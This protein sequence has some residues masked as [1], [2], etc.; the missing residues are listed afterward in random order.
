MG[1][2][3]YVELYVLPEQAEK[4]R[5]ICEDSHTSTENHDDYVVYGFEEVNYG[6]LEF[7]SDLQEAGIAFD[8]RWHG[9]Y[10]YGA[11]ILYS[12]FAPD[13]TLQ[14]VEVNDVETNTVPLD[15]LLEHI[16]LPTSTVDSIRNFVHDYTRS[17][18]PLPWGGQIENGKRYL[19]LKLIGGT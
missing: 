17:M 11:G 8:S 15:R 4:A 12:R 19:T 10:G 9:G 5:L 7:I 14:T 1:D 16:Q 2:R 18:T 13:G 6:T 3:C